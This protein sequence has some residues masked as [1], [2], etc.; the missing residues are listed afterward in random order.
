MSSLL[1]PLCSQTSQLVF[2][3]G[4]TSDAH[5]DGTAEGFFP[6]KKGSIL[7]PPPRNILQPPSSQH[8]SEDEHLPTS[9]SPS[10]ASAKSAPPS[11]PC[12]RVAGPRWRSRGRASPRRRGSALGATGRLGGGRYI[13]SFLIGTSSA[14]KHFVLDELIRRNLMSGR[15]FWIN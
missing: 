14:H 8:P 15:I 5:E 12:Y 10:S 4:K 2:L 1:I 9:R 11:S 6:L 7:Q 13:K 3:P